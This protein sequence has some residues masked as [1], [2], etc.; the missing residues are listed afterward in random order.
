[1]GQSTD[2]LL[3]YGYD[4]GCDEEWKV[5]EASGEYGELALPWYNPDA[6][7]EEDDSGFGTAAER[8]L[9]QALGFTETWETRTDDEY[10]AR[11]KAAKEQLG[12]EIETYC[13]DSYPM[14][15]LTAA[16]LTANRGYV[17]DTTEK[18]SADR[19]AWDERLAWALGALGLTPVQEKPAWL[20][21]S[22]ADGF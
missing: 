19:S 4:L 8:K 1:M 20:L 16:T 13:S 15:V 21:C 11:E 7:N 22:Y 14:Y 2:G 12:V 5:R 9:L 6:D 10:F 3:V 17:I 18:L